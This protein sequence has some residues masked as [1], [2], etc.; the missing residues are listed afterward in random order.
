MS[1]NNKYP[2]A[3]YQPL[4][5]QGKLKTEKQWLKEGY[6][7]KKNTGTKYWCNCFCEDVKL[8]Y[9]DKEV[10]KMT[11]KQLATYKKKV[12]LERKKK[13]EEKAK[14]KAEE[15]LQYL[16]NE[17]TAYHKLLRFNE[18]ITDGYDKGIDILDNPSRVVVF[19]TETTGVHPEEKDEI[20]QIT[21]IDGKG[22]E[23]INTLIKPILNDTW[24][25][26]E[27][28]NGISPDLVQNEGTTID[29]IIPII[30]GILKDA[31]VI[32]GYNTQFDLRFLHKYHLYENYDTEI[33]DVMLD[34]AEWYGEWNDYNGCYKWKKLTF[35]ADYFGFDWNSTGTHA[36]D[37][38]G[39]AMATLY[40]YKKLK[41]LKENNISREDYELKQKEQDKEE[42]RL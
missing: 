29:E 40:V 4:Y 20:L 19:D 14:R 24:E 21:M 8:Y 17:T 32:I 42:Y 26:A 1:R 11:D 41:Y 34:F 27:R 30:R 18:Y 37:S 31:D 13:K 3:N 22:N 15:H 10:K 35:S 5:R 16:E 9:T 7:P 28:I 38:L 12:S 33:K 6:K 25:K 36:H 2:V 23:L 39:D